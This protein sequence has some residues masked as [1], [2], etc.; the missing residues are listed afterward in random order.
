MQLCKGLYTHFGGGHASTC[1]R[2][3]SHVIPTTRNNYQYV[4]IRGFQNLILMF[5]FLLDS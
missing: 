4:L 2:V 3:I 1:T 5:S